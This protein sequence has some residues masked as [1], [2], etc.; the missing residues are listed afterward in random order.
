MYDLSFH[1]WEYVATFLFYF[2]IQCQG[3]DNS[4]HTECITRGAGGRRDRRGK[5][6]TVGNRHMRSVEG[7][8]MGRGTQG[9]Q[10][11]HNRD[12]QEGKQGI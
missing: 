3:S 1:E 5:H 6:K 2:Y 12:F 8:R 10:D 9:K 7:S 4:E 11:G